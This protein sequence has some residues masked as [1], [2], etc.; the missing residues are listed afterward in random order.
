MNAK[1]ADP[2]RHERGGGAETSPMTANFPGGVAQHSLSEDLLR[3]AKEI[4]EFLFGEARQRR[5]VYHLAHT[6][7]LPIFHVG[8]LLCSRRS[9]LL[10]WINEQDT[11]RWRG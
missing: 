10:K 6:T 5:K 4:S 1:S 8:S 9:A 7:G 11:G 2:K 3:G